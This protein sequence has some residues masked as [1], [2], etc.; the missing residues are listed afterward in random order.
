MSNIKNYVIGFLLICFSSLAY[1]Q[2]KEK[3]GK[4]TF[5]PFASRLLVL[6]L[7]NTKQDSL[8][9]NLAI[10]MTKI[11]SQRLDEILYVPVKKPRKLLA[12][13]S[14]SISK[15]KESY[16]REKEKQ[17]NIH[18]VELHTLKEKISL[19]KSQELHKLHLLEVAKI[20]DV[21]FVLSGQVKTQYSNNNKNIL[22]YHF[23]LCNANTGKISSF[24]V[25]SKREQAYSAIKPIVK[26]VESYLLGKNSSS[27]FF[28]TPKTGARI[29]I[30]NTFLGRTPFSRR[31][32]KGDYTVTV[33]QDQYQNFR[34][35]IKVYESK[36][37]FFLKGQRKKTLTSLYVDSK[38]KGAKVHINLDYKG[39]TPIHIQD[40]P[41]G[42][43]RIRISKEGFI[44]KNIGVNLKKEEKKELQV[45]LEKGDSLA[46]Y[47]K[48][49]TVIFHWTNK[50]LAL[51]SGLASA[52]FF[53]G[54]LYYDA[55]SNLAKDENKIEESKKHEN[56]AN[57][58]Q[59][60]S[61]FSL[62]LAGYFLYKTANPS[63]PI[64]FG[65]ISYNPAKKNYP[66]QWRL[67]F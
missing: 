53:A 9:N 62:V 63:P 57:T 30:E 4:L 40:A 43:H 20:Y 52:L 26:K 48:R 33:I 22:Q 46:Y 60:L 41:L 56:R 45:K 32:L 54:A 27:V 24:S 65:E 36:E 1:P 3:R 12:I 13:S 42:R 67:N 58:S 8:L 17:V 28:S 55:Q 44:E 5:Y 19:E 21:N 18:R 50:D 47:T 66:I 39:T 14:S 11:L 15:E 25:K 61:I 29:Y 35:K 51:Y 16:Y 10:S 59:N 7:K 37:R 64:L 38:P 6:P 2:N 23:Q 49:D 34:K 31:L